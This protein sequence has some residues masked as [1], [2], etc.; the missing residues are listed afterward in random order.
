MLNKGTD[1]TV[2]RDFELR[3]QQGTDFGISRGEA[4]D[5]ERMVGC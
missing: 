5:K 2:R 3:V 4:E 1:E